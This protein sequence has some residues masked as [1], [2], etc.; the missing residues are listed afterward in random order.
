MSPAS[1]LTWNALD[2]GGE[3][4][5]VSAAVCDDA[6]AEESD[7]LPAGGRARSQPPIR[8]KIKTTGQT[9]RDFLAQA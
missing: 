4:D 3:G 2:G 9:G 8:P 5:A 1:V 6:T 7:A